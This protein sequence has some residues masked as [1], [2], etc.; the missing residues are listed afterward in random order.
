MIFNI[1]SYLKFLLKSTNE[2]GIHSPFVFDYL[3]KCLYQKPQ[4]S[5][6]K[7]INVL[8]KSIAY[9]NAK[10]ILVKGN[11]SLKK[12]LEKNFQGVP[13]KKPPIDVLYFES[14]MSQNPDNVFSSF[15][16]HNDSLILFR[17]IYESRETF[18][19]WM[20]FTKSEKVTVSM[21]LFYCGLIFI[22]KEQVKQH[23]TIRI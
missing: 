5:K 8:L 6:D 16:L 10:S 2:H 12:E 7:V 19:H 3:T 23:F 1:K 9:F 14:P 20:E 11:N 15:P 18:L 17:G 13:E 4:K 22:R 21:D